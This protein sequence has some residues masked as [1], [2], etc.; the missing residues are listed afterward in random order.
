MAGR[1]LLVFRLLVR[2]LRRRRTETVLLLVAITAAT[3]TLTLGLALHHAFG[4]E[5][6]ETFGLGPLRSPSDSSM[7]ATGL[8]VLLAIAAL[9][10]IPAMAAAR[11][12]VAGSLGG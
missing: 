9:T 1:L 7:L 5:L 3:A 2:D 4:I 10:A 12:P 8:G 11:R 6:L